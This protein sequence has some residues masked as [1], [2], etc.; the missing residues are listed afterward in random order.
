MQA[1][2]ACNRKAI[3]QICN[4][5]SPCFLCT[6]PAPEKC[7]CIRGGVE[8]YQKRCRCLSFAVPERKCQFY[9]R[10]VSALQNEA[11]TA[12][13]GIKYDKKGSPWKVELGV[14]GYTGKRDSI[15]VNLGATYEFG[16]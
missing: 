15:G 11:Q 4:R 16:K 3:S 10:R 14:T 13:L 6:Q 5:F 8:A 12:E 1:L 9:P 7:P 2:Q